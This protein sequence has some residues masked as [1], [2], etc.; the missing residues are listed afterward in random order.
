MPR[1]LD[2]L[3]PIY[4]FL[5]AIDPSLPRALFVALIFGAVLLWRKVSPDTWRAYSNLIPVSD[6][7]TGRF[8]AVLKK[9]WQA[10]PSVLMSAIAGALGTG[11]NMGATI[12][13]ALL[14]LL[15][16]IIHELGWRYQGN[17]GDGKPLVPP[18]LP[19]PGQR[20]HIRFSAEA[21]PGPDDAA[22]RRWARPAWYLPLAFGAFALLPGCGLLGGKPPCDES[23]LEAIDAAY[24]SQMG[25]LCLPKYDRKEDCPDYPRL[26]T[27]HRQRLAD[28]CGTVQQ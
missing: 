2:Y 23:K 22:I 19:S 27:E 11:G 8:V 20:D 14:G 15:P 25:V 26:K 12:K 4:A 17:L 6:E 10:L 24:I 21:D 13:I 28:E 9:T 1:L 7:Q 18:S 16:P 5:A 3:N